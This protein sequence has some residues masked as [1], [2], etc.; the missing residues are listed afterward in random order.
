M[1]DAA[2]LRIQKRMQHVDSMSPELRRLV[3][4]YGFDM[5]K[6]FLQCGVTKPRQIEHLI[7][8][9]R[10]GSGEIGDRKDAPVVR[11]E[12]WAAKALNEGLCELRLPAVGRQ[13]V[14]FLR[15][16]GKLI[17]ASE[18]RPGAITASIQA[19]NNAGLGNRWVDTTTKHRIRLRRA[20]AV[21]GALEMDPP[22][23]QDAAA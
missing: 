9:V 8:V 10:N 14:A 13:L 20:L 21:A 18:P 3:H 4:D 15:I 22:D 2:V 7:H 16:H 12:S 5:V 6:Q 23:L 11:R 1:D 19:L 17:V